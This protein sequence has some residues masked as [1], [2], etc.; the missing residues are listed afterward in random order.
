MDAVTYPNE[1]VI[2]F[3]S[4]KIVGLRAPFDSK[5]LSTDFSVKWTPTLVVTDWDGKEHNRTVGFLPPEELIP[6]LL[7]GMAKCDFDADRFRQA[8]ALLDALLADYPWSSAAPEA[9]FLRGVSRFKAANDPAPLKE[10][11][12]KL[13]VDYPESEW[14]KRASP[15]GLL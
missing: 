14:V 1:K 7:L 10:A 4:K 5:P 11:Y 9:V 12:E 13:R 15:Y 2:E 6:S 8:I 3:F